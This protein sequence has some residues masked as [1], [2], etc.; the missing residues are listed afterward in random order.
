MKNSGLSIPLLKEGIPNDINSKFHRRKLLSQI[1]EKYQIMLDK[2]VKKRE[3]KIQLK[4]EKRIA[5]QTEAL[6]PEVIV[7]RDVVIKIKPLTDASKEIILAKKKN[8]MLLLKQQVQLNGI[9]EEGKTIRDIIRRIAEKWDLR[10]RQIELRL[11]FSPAEIVQK[12]LK[13]LAKFNKANSAEV[14]IKDIIK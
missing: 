13:N 9:N 12:E 3:H 6:K 2:Q 7:V 10:Q 4:E 5:S 14:Q 1:I 8:P 11:C